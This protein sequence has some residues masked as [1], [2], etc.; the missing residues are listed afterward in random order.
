MAD[1]GRIKMTRFQRE[2]LLGLLCSLESEF[3]YLR[4]AGHLAPVYFDRVGG[5]PFVCLEVGDVWCVR[6]CCSEWMEEA[7]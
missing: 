2:R 3:S 1:T 6:L 5:R 7:R 4:S